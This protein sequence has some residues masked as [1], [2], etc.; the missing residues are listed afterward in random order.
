MKEFNVPKNVIEDVVK[1]LSNQYHLESSMLDTIIQS[2]E[3][4]K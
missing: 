2:I 3:E 4:N 1:Y